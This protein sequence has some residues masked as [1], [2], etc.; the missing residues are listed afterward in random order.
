MPATYFSKPYVP[1]TIYGRGTHGANG[2]PN[3]LFIAF[4]FSDDGFRVQFLRDVGLFP[5]SVVCCKCRS[6][7]SLC[8]DCSVTAV[9]RWRYL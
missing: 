1:S 4:L 2:A 9:Y 8:V 6:H 3:K 7:M 5:N